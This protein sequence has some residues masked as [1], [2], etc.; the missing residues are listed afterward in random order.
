[1]YALYIKDKLMHKKFMLRNLSGF[2]GFCTFRCGILFGEFIFGNI[3]DAVFG[4]IPTIFLIVTLIIPEIYIQFY[5]KH[6]KIHSENTKI[7]PD[8]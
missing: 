6:D 7:N 5:F 2:I 4:P 3:K 1:M 8:P